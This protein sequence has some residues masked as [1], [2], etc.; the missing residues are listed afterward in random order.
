MRLPLAASLAGYDR[1][2]FAD[3][4]IAGTITAL[5]LVPQALAYALLAGLP[6]QVGLY[7]SMLPP[8]IYALLG[9]SRT[10]AVGPVAVAAVMVAAALGPY[11]GGDPARYLA[12]A[13]ILAAEVGLLLALLGALRLGALTSFIGHPVLTGFTAAAALVIIASQLGPLTGIALAGHGLLA[14]AASLLGGLGRLHLPTLLLSLAAIALL[15][16][17]RG[18]LVH[19]LMTLGC[20]ARQAQ[21]LSRLGPLAVMAA[22]LAAMALAGPQHAGIAVLGTVPNGLPRPTLGFLDPTGWRALAPSAVLIALVGYVESVSVAKTLAARRRERID[23][24]QELLALGGANLASALSGAMPV[25]GG[26]SRSVVNF[27]AGA[28]TQLAAIVTAVLVALIALLAGDA[29]ALLPRAA[30]AAV[31]VVSVAQL[32]DPAHM[33]EI[34]RFDRA[35]GSAMLAT[36][37]GVLLL[38]IEQGLL[39]GVV[40]ALALY[41]HRTSRPHIAIV[42]RI[43]GTEHFR[44]VDRERVQTQPGCMAIRIDE[45]LYFGNVGPVQDFILGAIAD[46]PDCHDL[47]LIMSA[48]NHVDSSG[49]ELLEQLRA[50]LAG[51]GVGLHLTEV[52]GPVMD[53]LRHSTLLRGGAHPPCP[54]HRSTHDALRALAGPPPAPPRT[55]E[56]TG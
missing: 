48:V 52:K 42:G 20:P 7:A 15:L 29:L 37:G 14:H 33:R 34:W 19:G 41:L 26:F 30:L 35:D 50:D 32:I 5:L 21:I 22:A 24:D 27:D 8:V 3:D 46:A 23:P 11:A 18:P 28:R 17:A 45:N 40:V 51:A 2:A 9:S 47:V 53:R 4:L 31:I 56:K 54:V 16:L 49:L 43:P 6:A 38:G 39:L 13:T 25:A 44:N 55:L 1:G 12:G 36:F 10:L